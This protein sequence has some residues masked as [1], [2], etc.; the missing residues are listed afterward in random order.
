MEGTLEEVAE[1]TLEEGRRCLDLGEQDEWCLCRQMWT[2]SY[3][4]KAL[5]YLQGINERPE[6]LLH[7]GTF[8]GASITT[9]Q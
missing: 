8:T 9:Q 1:E 4:G 7:S 5:T 2:T 6:N 3:S